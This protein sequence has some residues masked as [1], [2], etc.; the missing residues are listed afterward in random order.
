M[1]TPFVKASAEPF[2]FRV[3]HAGKRL[4]AVDHVK[5]SPR[6]GQIVWYERAREADAHLEVIDAIAEGFE[7]FARRVFEL[8]DLVSNQPV[9]REIVTRAFFHEPR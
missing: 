1:L 9:E 2:A 8:V 6:F 3:R 5:L 7:A 4:P